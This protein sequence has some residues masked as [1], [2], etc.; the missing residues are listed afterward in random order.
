MA[1]LSRDYRRILFQ[2]EVPCIEQTYFSLGIVAF[3]SLG[4]RRREDGIVLPP[5]C[6][7]RDLVVV[8]VL[9]P[10][11]VQGRVGAVVVEERQLNR[12][13]AGPVESGLIEGPS[14]GADVLLIADAFG[15]LELRRLQG[16]KLAH[17]GFGFRIAIVPVRNDVFRPEGSESF[18]VRVTVLRDDGLNAIRMSGGQT[19]TNRRAVVLDID[20]ISRYL[21]LV[22]QVVGDQQG[23]RRCN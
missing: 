15:V 18:V 9:V 5:Y 10:D 20:G 7:E 2:R 23:G 21:E 6:E 11:W 12:V 22:E 8:Q 19:K 13:V 3:E 14:V 17:L 4:A 1:H 16:Q